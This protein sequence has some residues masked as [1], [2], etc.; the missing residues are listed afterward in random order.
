MISSADYL[1]SLKDGYSLG[2]EILPAKILGTIEKFYSESEIIINKK[3]KTSEKLVNIRPMISLVSYDEKEYKEKLRDKLMNVTRLENGEKSYFLDIESM[4]QVYD[5]DIK[6]YIQLDTGS[7][8]NLKPELVMEA[9]C[10]DNN[11]EYNSFAWQVHRLELYTRDE[12][13]KKLIPLDN[14]DKSDA[15]DAFMSHKII[16]TRQDHT[17]LSLQYLKGWIWCRI[18]KS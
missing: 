3:T 15:G 13:T 10:K 2:E 7:V 9:F 16:I 12:K 1:I 5:N 14:L 4:A 17:I 18:P 6:V 8:S 11:I